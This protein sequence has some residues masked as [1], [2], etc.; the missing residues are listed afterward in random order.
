MHDR[1]DNDLVA[2]RAEVHGVWKA[3]HEGAPGITLHMGIGERILENR[4][5]RC[6]DGRGEGSAE[7]DTLSLIPRS[8][9]Q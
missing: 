6:F 4:G 5:D 2:D 7:S 3:T 1:Q 8:P 9:I